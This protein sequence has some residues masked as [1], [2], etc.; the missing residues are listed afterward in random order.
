MREVLLVLAGLAILTFTGCNQEKKE[1]K[2]FKE[3][4]SMESNVLFTNQ[5]EDEASY[6]TLL[7]ANFY[8][9]AGVGI[10]DINNDGLADLFFAG[11]QVSDKLYLNKG[12]FKFEDITEI[13]G[14]I[15]NEGW[16]SSVL[17]GDVNNDGYLDIY[18]T[19]EMYGNS[20]QLLRNKLY[21][22][23]QDNSFTESSKLWG[24]DNAERSR[25]GTF[26][27]FD[28]DGDLD[29]YLLNTPPNPGPLIDTDVNDLLEERYSPVL[30][31]NR[32]KRFVDV[33][34]KS[35][36]LRP[37]FP[38]SVVA[39][40]LNGDGWQDLYVTNDFTVPDF[41]F[42]NNGDGTFSNRIN[43]ITGHISF[44][45]MGVDASD[46]D[47]DGLLDVFVTDMSAED[48]YRIKSN[49]SG[50][51]PEA[52]WS[53]VEKGD[54]HQYMYNT[55]QLNS[56][57]GY[58]SDIAQIA[59]LS[60][61]DWS[62]SSF[63]ADFDNDGYKDA[64]ISNGILREIRN[65]DAL[66]KLSEYAA[67]HA[68]A[69]TIGSVESQTNP[70]I[71]SEHL[72]QMIK[73]FP[74]EKL[75]NYAYR[76]NGDHT[77]EKIMNEWGITAKSFSNGSA[78]GDLDNDGDLDL[79]INNINQVAQ[80]LENRSVDMGSHYIR[81]KLT[82][83]LN[84]RTNLGSKI[85]LHTESGLQFFE[86]T[87]SRGM[88]SSSEH[89]VHFGLG[90]ETSI[91]KVIVKW[92]DGKINTIQDPEL[93]GVLEVDYSTAKTESTD[94]KNEPDNPIYRNI[95]DHASNGIIHSEN[96]FD[97]YQLQV[98]LPHKMSTYGPALA[99]GD[100]NGDGN[101]DFYLGGAVGYAGQIITQT[102]K[103]TF[104]DATGYPFKNDKD[105]ED[106][107]AAFL[108]VDQDGDLDLY[109]VSG[110]NEYPID[111]KYYRDRLYINNG[112]GYFERATERL[113]DLRISGSR[114]FPYD[115]DGDQDVDLFV[116][117]HHIP[118]DY[119]APA[120]SALLVN[121]GGYFKDMTDELAPGLKSIGMINDAAWV[122]IDND[123]LQDLVLV[124][125]WTPVSVFHNT[126]TRFEKKINP[127]FEQKTT[128]WWFS[129]EA[130]DM[131]N[132]GDQDLVVGNLGLNH[133][134]KAS[135]EEPFK[136]YYD[137]FDL[138]GS[139]D[140]VLAYYNFGDLF[141]LRGRSC[142]SEQVPQLSEKFSTYN[143]FAE[144]DIVSVYGEKNLENALEYQVSTFASTYFEND[145]TGQFTPYQLPTEAQ[146]SSVNDI[147]LT[148]ANRDQI[149]DII[150]A[151]NLYNSEV[152]TPRND[153]G[154]ALLLTGMG[155]R[156]FNAT[157]PQKSG[158]FI[159]YEVKRLALI[160]G[161][162]SDKLLAGCNDEKVQIFQYNN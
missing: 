151:G 156:E 83:K 121:Q 59:G 104:I 142:S 3:V 47:N 93:N 45:S 60:S 118:G 147:L 122:D 29:L 94:E 97:D 40:D 17:M 41:L 32:G 70:G 14:I 49:M 71:D 31:E 152:E 161:A 144:S 75:L 54:H 126:G 140:I 137:D 92:S 106:V 67:N 88:Y 74:S 73:L 138:N 159:P 85:W 19:R 79:V 149:M 36:L 148:D 52:F 25:A 4:P 112:K 12:D 107:G 96:N 34:R 50:M 110:G 91:E 58:F 123:S 139:K 131:D 69:L 108:D 129:I 28:N 109:V 11:N 160:Q 125:E 72:A 1:E 81:I 15:D 61:T 102:S 115:F 24:V 76:N 134:Y 33:T 117:G 16:S 135:V 127:E 162:T 98:L 46:I 53:V 20:P 80:I 51:N 116:A 158:L 105:F 37:G 26:F 13:A 136:V 153:A 64:F 84:N 38:N 5:L 86:L 68:W 100:I 95:T 23:N 66:K 128:G 30:Y 90:E 35:G 101:E 42:I 18:V 48:N 114:V 43:E 154:Y 7:Q 133:K 22:N 39:A 63:F 113:P 82:D 132:D 89:A 87:G 130:A 44:G 141:P 146:F 155:N 2:L 21:I 10:G 124:G 55:L 120:S 111:S 65:T 119:P 77:F 56:G 157:S 62:W 143:L 99:T 145:G 78:Y 9:G 150:I 27:D 103:G 6:N 8:G 57:M